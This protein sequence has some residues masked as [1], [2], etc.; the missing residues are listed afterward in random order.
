MNLNSPMLEIKDLKVSINENEI[1]KNFSL[2]VEKGE[3]HAIMGPNGSGK[4]TFSKVI[5]GHPAYNVSSGDILLKGSSIL[6]LDPEDRSHLGIFLAFQYPI[7][8]PGVS[9]ED[10]LRLAYNSKQKFYNKPEVDPLEFL[11]IIN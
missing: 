4:S 1:L 11:S 5:A 6:E 2:K 7:E 3:I 10:F 8:I 9:N